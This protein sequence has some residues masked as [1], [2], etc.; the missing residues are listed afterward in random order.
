M[1][2][3]NHTQR[4]TVDDL[5]KNNKIV[6]LLELRRRWQFVRTMVVLLYPFKEI[7]KKIIFISETTV[8]GVQTSC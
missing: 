1:M 6:S 5:L 8:K 2:N 3:P 4:P 7:I